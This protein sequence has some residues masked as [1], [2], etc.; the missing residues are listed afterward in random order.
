[1]R[2]ELVTS[3]TPQER[4]LDEA[5]ARLAAC[6]EELSQR[7]LELATLQAEVTAF[8]ARYLRALGSRFAE[9][10][11][12]E[13][14]IAEILARSKPSDPEVRRQAESA[15]AQADTSAREANASA[16][17]PDRGRFV[18]SEDIKKLYRAIAMKVHPDR[19]TDDE[20]RSRRTRIMAEVNEA[21]SQGDLVR[22]RSILS[23]WETS[24]DAIQGEDVA[25]RL[26]KAVRALRQIGD[27]ITSILLEV[28]RVRQTEMYRLMVKCGEAEEAGRDLLA[29]MA[30]DLAERIAEVRRRRDAMTSAGRSK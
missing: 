27:R 15:R 20:S 12:I 13:A 29:E 17:A 19:A 7:E 25:S 21:Y 18:P 30:E 24:S 4:E 1:M 23:Q 2:R 11:A 22:L 8:N 16:C 6:E 10:D 26:S 3:K 14:E 5:L 9:L 28:E